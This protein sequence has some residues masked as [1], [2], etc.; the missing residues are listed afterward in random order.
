MMT[1]QTE[2]HNNVQE[3]WNNTGL[4]IKAHC[5]VA[6]SGSILSQTLLNLTLKE[7]RKQTESLW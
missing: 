2:H 7:N 5:M 3:G 6:I 4:Y 1:G